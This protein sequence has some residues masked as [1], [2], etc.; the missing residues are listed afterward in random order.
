MGITK[1]DSQGALGALWVVI[2]GALHTVGAQR[3]LIS[4]PATS[5][6]VL[7]RSFSASPVSLSCVSL[8]FETPCLKVALHCFSP[9]TH[10]P[11]AHAASL[12]ERLF[13]PCGHA[14]LTLCSRATPSHPSKPTLAVPSSLYLSLKTI[15]S[16]CPW[17]EQVFRIE[18]S[19]LKELR[20]TFPSFHT[21]CGPCPQRFWVLTHLM[22]KIT[23]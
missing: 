9:P 20:V 1:P 11:L 16:S 17:A 12:L 4:F 8:C 18:A 6:I 2:I 19:Y 21:W 22:P 3:L 23:L 10:A 13:L 5:P 15:S 7:S 14:F